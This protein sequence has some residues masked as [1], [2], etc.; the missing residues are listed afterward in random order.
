MLT[1]KVFI[2]R[3]PWIANDGHDP[4]VSTQSTFVNPASLR[5]GDW[6]TKKE[7]LLGWNAQ[8]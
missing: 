2:G 4:D 8:L 5:N 7:L 6:K 1:V 3:D